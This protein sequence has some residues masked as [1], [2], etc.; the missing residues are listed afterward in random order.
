MEN[1]EAHNLRPGAA[2]SL[3][4]VI[5]TIV[6]AMPFIVGILLSGC[7]PDSALKSSAEDAVKKK[8]N[9]PDSAKFEDVYV[10]KKID[11]GHTYSVICGRVNAR[12]AL[13]G[14]IG[15]SRFIAIPGTKA[16]IGYVNI[17]DRRDRSPTIGDDG[18]PE[19]TTLF[20][21]LWWNMHC[22]DEQHAPTHMGK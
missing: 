19:K 16:P 13:G 3:K 8:L 7:S 12:N 18:K 6:V 9:D 14:Y 22:V 5:R 11:K 20:E 21:L 4:S 17:E 15:F 2:L 1:T 10:V